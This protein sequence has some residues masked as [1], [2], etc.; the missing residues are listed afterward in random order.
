VLVAGLREDSAKGKVK[1]DFT[2]PY[3]LAFQ[4]CLYGAAKMA[5]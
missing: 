4:K 3:M 5:T 2:K 1:P